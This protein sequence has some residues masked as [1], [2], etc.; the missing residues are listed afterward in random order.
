MVTIERRNLAL[1]CGPAGRYANRENI[2]AGHG[3]FLLGEEEATA[4]FDA[5]VE[6]VA[7]QWRPVM[8]RVGVTDA[9]CEAIANAFNYD[10]LF[11]P[12]PDAG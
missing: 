2:I 9:D 6:T 1:A 4:I 8:R 3:R 12:L 10:G 11:Y 5:V 7:N